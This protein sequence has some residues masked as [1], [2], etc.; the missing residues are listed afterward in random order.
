MRGREGGKEGGMDRWRE[1]GRWREGDG[2][3]RRGGGGTPPS[4]AR[5]PCMRGTP[6]P[7][8]GLCLGGRE[9]RHP[10]RARDVQ[11]YS[12]SVCAPS[13]SQLMYSRTA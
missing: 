10:P 13:I 4:R 9:G 2:D 12:P 8:E 1:E 6:V 11:M 3:G 5:Y 7:A